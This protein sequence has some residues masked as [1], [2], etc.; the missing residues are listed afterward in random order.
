[1]ETEPSVETWLAQTKFSPPRLRESLIPRP[2]LVA[3]LEAA[4]TQC[5]LT[6]V[7]APAGCGKTTLL[8]DFRFP[9]ADFGSGTRDVAIANRQP[10]LSVAEGSPIANRAAWLSLDDED[11]DPARFLA[12]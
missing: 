12:A 7:S 9:I 10:V 11:N 4:L 2:R 6:L 1:M 3:A 8:S 5:P